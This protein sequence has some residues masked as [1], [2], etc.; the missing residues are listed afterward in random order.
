M[1]GL[2]TSWCRP[3]GYCTPCGYLGRGANCIIEM[4]KSM[5]V[6]T[7]MGRGAANAGRSTKPDARLVPIAGADSGTDRAGRVATGRP[8]ADRARVVRATRD[9]SDAGAARARGAD[10]ARI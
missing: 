7:S 2:T 5:R 9:Q 4:T 6:A 3:D 8:A 1:E 10:G